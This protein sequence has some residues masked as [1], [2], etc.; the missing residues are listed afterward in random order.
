M[1]EKL[2]NQPGHAN[3]TLSLAGRHWAHLPGVEGQE[4]PRRQHA[5]W[6]RIQH[7]YKGPRHVGSPHTYP[8][9]PLYPIV[10]HVA[11]CATWFI[12]MRIHC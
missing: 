5:Q 1:T 11:A 8:H 3:P 9:N 6:Q 10:L 12:F 7:G 2:R 4:Q